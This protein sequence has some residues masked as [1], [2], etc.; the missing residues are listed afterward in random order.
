M[1]SWRDAGELFCIWEILGSFLDSETSKP[2]STPVNRESIAVKALAATFLSPSSSYFALY[3]CSRAADALLNYLT[4][5]SH[6]QQRKFYNMQTTHPPTSIEVKNE[7][8]YISTPPYTFMACTGTLLLLV[9]NRKIPRLFHSKIVHNILCWLRQR[10]NRMLLLMMMMMMMM[11]M[12]LRQDTK[13]NTR[14]SFGLCRRVFAHLFYIT[15]HFSNLAYSCLEDGGSCFL[16]P[17]VPPV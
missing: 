1:R 2:N 5:L 16:Q 10:E 15:N 14:K 8:R 13:I 7:W 3:M 4:L 12:L 11:M 9:L 6:T 17:L